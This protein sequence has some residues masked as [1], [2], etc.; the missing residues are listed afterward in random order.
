MAVE[1]RESGAGQSAIPSAPQSLRTAHS[2]PARM[3]RRGWPRL[4]ACNGV[5]GCCTFAVAHQ[6]EPCPKILQGGLTTPIR[7]C[8]LHFSAGNSAH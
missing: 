1:R 6:Y 4:G 7:P 5:T 2:G 8:Y 3:A